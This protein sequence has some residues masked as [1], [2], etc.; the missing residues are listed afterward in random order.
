[1]LGESLSRP[2][3]IK[4]SC[5][6]GTGGSSSNLGRNAAEGRVA[7]HGIVPRRARRA[8][9]GVSLGIRQVHL[10]SCLRDQVVA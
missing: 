10:G 4:A 1:M 7:R 5:T 3:F 2:H 9:R 6:V 8:G